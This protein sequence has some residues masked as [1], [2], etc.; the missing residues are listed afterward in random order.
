MLVTALIYV[1]INSGSDIALRGWAIPVATDIAFAVGVLSLLGA[2]VP[3]SLKLFLLAL[4][5][6]DDLG[7]ILIIA[8]FYT[9]DLSALSLLLAVIGIF[10]L[11]ALNL[12]GVTRIAPYVLVGAFIWVCVLKS[13][14]HATVAGVVVAFA[15]PLRAVGTASYSPLERGHHRSP[16]KFRYGASPQPDP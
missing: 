10:A 1:A 16:G 14:V 8:L 3:T 4:A 12:R 2:R 9:A 5:I 15:V 6:V 13:G 7:A 11:V